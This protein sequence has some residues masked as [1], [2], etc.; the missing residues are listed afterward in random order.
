M[1]AVDGV[2]EAWLIECCPRFRSMFSHLGYTFRITKS[3]ATRNLAEFT[4][5]LH[6]WGLQTD[7]TVVEN[8]TVCPWC[9]NPIMGR[10]VRRLLP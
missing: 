2:Y 7:G 3:T 5:P 1:D 9:S 8:M 6:M 10:F 4:A